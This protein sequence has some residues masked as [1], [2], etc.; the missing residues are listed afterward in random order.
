MSSKS[1]A[2]VFPNQLFSPNP[3]LGLANEFWLV[4]E[5]L[6]F[7]EFNFHKLKLAFHRAS[8]KEYEQAL[9]QDDLLVHYVESQELIADI[10]ELVKHLALSGVR[11][12]EV[13]DPVDDWLSRR[14][15]NST[16]KAGLELR[17]HESPMFLNSDSDVLKYFENRK[18][19][20]QTTFYQDQRRKHGWLMNGK[21][22]VGDKWSFDG[23]NRKRLPAGYPVPPAPVVGLSVSWKEAE[24]YVM[25]H[26]PDNPGVL[27]KMR[28]P[29]NHSD[30]NLWFEN[31]LETRF[32]DF[33]SFED[34]MVSRQ[35]I[36]FHS[37]L[38]PMMN[39]GLISPE[40][41]VRRSL[42][43]DV[44][45]D[46]PLNSVEGF[47]RQVAGWRE[48]I[49]AVYVMKGRE[50]R[51]KNYWSFK[52]RIPQSFYSGN[53]GIPPLDMV[54]ESVNQ[55]A[56]SH[57]IERLMILGNF[58]LLCEFDPDEVYRWFMEMFIDA[59]DWVMVP[60]VY[61]MSQFAD[62]GI[63]ATKPYI[64]GS[65]YILKMSDFKKG[66]WQE[67]W[68]SLFWRFMAVHR[69]FFSS[70]PRLSM[71]L[72]TWDGFDHGKKKALLDRAENYLAALG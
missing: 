20:F 16:A 27:G 24:Q 40:T 72:R 36:L 55:R 47:L 39:I 49:R 1:A 65:N 10:R 69:D 22:P 25:H 71:L 6:F 37:V 8:M 38:S 5:H 53:T 70:N 63:F 31:F 50:E 21:S 61:G 68:D 59:Y 57:H 64:S 13:V 51:T 46:I 34:A 7:R 30:A 33:G 29:V 3:L 35:P 11:R 17:I 23:E 44:Q 42:E 19:Y 66:E 45:N 9:R 56:Y 14:L 54:I 48:F 52:R 58:M 18:Q 15:Q 26:F 60:N 4:E 32:R 28:Y 43:Y 41:V 2:I 62:G 67:V 12:I